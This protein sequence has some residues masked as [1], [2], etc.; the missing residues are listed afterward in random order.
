M[1]RFSLKRWWHRRRPGPWRV[2]ATVREADDI[3]DVIP[4]HEA[5]LVRSNQTLKWLVLDCPCGRGHRIMLNLDP[6]RWPTWNIV[7]ESPLTVWPS[8][9][10]DCDTRRCH[11]VISYGNID[12]IREVKHSR[13]RTVHFRR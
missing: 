7:S 2:T 6:R 12:W 10:V 4:R 3:P 8:V 9:D 5:T 1:A 11:Y 13:L